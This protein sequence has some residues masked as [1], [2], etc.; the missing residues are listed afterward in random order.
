MT[1]GGAPPAPK[2]KCMPSSV[3]AHTPYKGL[4]IQTFLRVAMML[5]ASDHSWLATLHTELQIILTDCRNVAM[6]GQADGNM[7]STSDDYSDDY[8]ST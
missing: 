2:M 7:I 4:S 6:I 3:A 5:I 8:D 1:S